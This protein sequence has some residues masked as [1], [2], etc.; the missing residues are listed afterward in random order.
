MI[1]QVDNP[2]EGTIEINTLEYFQKQDAKFELL[3]FVTPYGNGLDL[4]PEGKTWI[5]DVSDYAPILK[6]EKYLSLEMGGQW[7]EEM[8]IEFWFITGTPPR[9][10]LGIQNVWPFRRGWFDQ[11]QN[12]RFFEPRTLEFMPDADAVKIRAAITG[13]GQNG[14]FVPREHY[15][16]IDGGSQEFTFDVW[17]ECGDNPVYPQGGTWIFDRAGW[18]PGMA[19]DVHEYDLSPWAATSSTAQID[20]GVNGAFMA[21]A[22]YLVSA[23]VVSYGAHNFETEASIENIIRPTNRVEYERINPA[24]NAPMIEVKNNGFAPLTQLTIEYGVTGGMPLTHEWTG[25]IPF[26][27]TQ[28]IELPVDNLS[29]WSTLTENPQFEVALTQINGAANDEVAYNNQLSNPFEAPDVYDFPDLQLRTYTNNRASENRFTITDYAGN[30]VLERDNMDNFTT[31]K[32]LLDFAP[33]C[34]TLTFEDD[35][36][37][38]LQFWYWDLIGEDV[39]SGNLRLERQVLPTVALPIYYFD[40]DFGGDLHYDF[41]I[42]QTNNVTQ[43]AT[44]QRLSIF[45]SPTAG[46]LTVEWQGQEEGQFEIRV[47]NMA[48]ILMH[49]EMVEHIPGGLTQQQLDLS[50]FPDG[51]YVVQVV[52]TQKTWVSE[53]VKQ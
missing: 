47:L 46:P 41:T 36:D 6:G 20:Y 16:D 10:V 34:Y 42:P 37:D 23:Q 43:T 28:M 15:I 53:V 22:N 18:C 26:G 21:E 38:G 31:Y 2:A 24:C 39:G 51:M 12:D 1:G 30:I 8:D 50:N 11:I 3:S 29:F 14:E 32:D 33:G 13:H 7:Q 25:T 49:R 44:T 35:G 27:A 5:F 48:G 4:G 52:G 19:T 9:E 40:S 17:K 45:P